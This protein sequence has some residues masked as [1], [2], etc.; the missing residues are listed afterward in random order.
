MSNILWI[1]RD[2]RIHDNPALV[3]AVEN[4]VSIAVFIST[5]QQWQQHHLAPIKADFIYRHL[6]QLESQLAEFG[7]SL[8]HLKA[9]DFDDQARQLIELYEQLDAKCVY[10]NSEPEVD[11]QTRDQ[12]LI[13][14]GVNLQISSCDVMLPLGSVLNKQGEMFKVFT[15]FK[16][17][18]LKEVQVKGI[19]CSPAPIVPAKLQQTQLQQ[20]QLQQTQRPQSQ[21]PDDLN[22]SRISADYDFDFP[23]VDSS[24][25]PLSQDVLGNVIPNFLTN[26]VNDYTRLR[27]I[28]SVKGTSGLS[29]YLAI[30]AVSPRWLAIQLIQQQP[31]LLFD[32]QL[33]AFSWL[34]ELIWRDFYKHLMFHHPKLVKGANFQ[35]KYNGLDWYQ[36]HPSFKAWC[37]GKTGYPLVD[38]AMRQLVET[39][40]MHNRLRMVVA[41]FLTKHLLIDWRWGERFFMSHLIDGDFSA[42]NG[43]WQ[44]ASSTGCDAQPYFRIFNPITQSE[45]FDPKGIFIRKYIPELQNIPDK[46]VHFP[47]DFIAKNGIDSEYWQPIVEHKQ[48]RL[49][50]LAFFK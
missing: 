23:R 33:P 50:A 12:Q 27:D 37:E 36:D 22:A 20:T 4:G 42:N 45:K 28:P 46:H 26:K 44:W 7:I 8:L 18:W 29:P 32:T 48:A 35:Q 34:N 11:E 1:R 3:A 24:R 38:A 31:D 5:P 17:A 14:N 21:L 30:G 49:R 2:L 47:H 10:A 43:G 39:G 19:I 6:K 40:W 41:S 15:P 9:S 13:S 16:N 25:W